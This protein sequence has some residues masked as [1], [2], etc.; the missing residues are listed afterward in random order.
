MVSVEPMSYI[1]QVQL[2]LHGLLIQILKEKSSVSP[3][4]LVAVAFE[5]PKEDA[6]ISF[7]SSLTILKIHKF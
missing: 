5:T 6:A 1:K 2:F 4:H 7:C 3:S